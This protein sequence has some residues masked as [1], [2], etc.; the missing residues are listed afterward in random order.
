MSE[1]HNKTIPELLEI[2]REILEIIEL[3]EMENA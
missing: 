2:I 1:L 3:K